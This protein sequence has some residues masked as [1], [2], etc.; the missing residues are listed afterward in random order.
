[1]YYTEIIS[2]IKQI[3]IGLKISRKNL[4]RAYFDLLR[5]FGWK[6]IHYGYYRNNSEDIV[7]AQ[8]NLS[9]LVID[10]IPIGTTDIIDIGG[11]VGSMARQLLKKNYHCLCVVPDKNFIKYG[12]KINPEVTFLQVSAENLKTDNQFDLAVLVESYQ[13]FADP[14]LAIRNI[15]NCLRKNS[16][17]II[18]DEFEKKGRVLANTED[19]LIKTLSQNNYLLIK[20]QNL[21]KNILPTADFVIKLAKNLH[22]KELAKIWFFIKKEYNNGHREYLLLVFNK[23]KTYE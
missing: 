15:V 20:K 7:V 1:M 11:G 17:L 23:Q 16:S 12:K 18:L 10:N 21:T 4:L 14:E 22:I 5:V 2:K 8:E 9:R 3:Y 13:Y 19:K 6:H